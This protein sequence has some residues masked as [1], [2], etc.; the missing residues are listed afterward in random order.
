MEVQHV[1]PEDFR[2]RPVAQTL[3]GR[4]IVQRHQRRKPGPRA[5]RPVGLTGPAAPQPPDRIFHPPLSARGRACRSSRSPGRGRGVRA[6]GRTRSRCRRCRSGARGRARDPAAARG[7]GRWARRRC[8]G[9]AP[10]AAGGRGVQGGSAPLGRRCGT[11][12]DR[13]PTARGAGGRWPWPAVRRAGGGGG[14]GPPDARAAG[15]GPGATWRGVG[16][17][18]RPGPASGAWFGR[19]CS[20]RWSRGQARSGRRPAAAD[21]RAVPATSLV[22]GACV[23]ARAGRQPGRGGPRSSAGRGPAPGHPAGASP[24][25]GRECVS[26]PEQ[27]SMAR[28]PAL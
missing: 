27:W 22:C 3:A 4:M 17:G 25:A 7:P 26:A 12:S 21:R 20:D 28:D 23:P 1:V 9:A 5:G 16:S 13:L 18:A 19:S 14:S 15:G 24:A 11:A 8:P 6:G 10:P 2:G